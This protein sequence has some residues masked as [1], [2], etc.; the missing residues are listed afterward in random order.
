M[1]AWENRIKFLASKLPVFIINVNG[2]SGS[3][4]TNLSC[5]LVD[6]IREYYDLAIYIKISDINDIDALTSLTQRSAILVLEDFTFLASKH[7]RTVD[8][9]LRELMLVRHSLGKAAIIV[10]SHYLTS[11][12]PIL[13]MSHVRALTSLTSTSEIKQFKH[14]FDLTALWDFYALYTDN[15][16]S[17]F[18][19]L[20]ILGKHYIIRPPLS[21][22]YTKTTK[23]AKYVIL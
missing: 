7:S 6:L 1:K 2:I 4:K 8:Q 20:N 19:L 9:F 10:I 18:A 14:L 12:L 13:R 17:H 11:V 21:K 15:P 3:G 16:A 23:T 5:V 22:L